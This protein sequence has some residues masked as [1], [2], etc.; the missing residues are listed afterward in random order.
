MDISSLALQIP[1]KVLV[2]KIDESHSI[3][4]LR[5][6]EKGYGVTLGNT[7]RRVL[8]SS[9]EGYAITAIKVGGVQHEFSTIQGVREDL[10]EIIL[11]LKQVRLKNLGDDADFGNKI[12]LR[13]NKP[14]FRAGDIDKVPSNF[15]VLN[16]D[17]LICNLEDSA[18]LDI[19]LYIEKG[20]GYHFADDN[21]SVDYAVGVIPIDSV[22]SPIV[23]V[24]YRVENV[25]VAQR[26][27]YEELILEVQTDGSLSPEEGLKQASQLVV[28]YLNLLFLKEF[29]LRSNEDEGVH[30][31]NEEKLIVQKNLSIRISDL[32]CSVRVMNCLRSA[33]V[34][35]LADLVAMTDFDMMKFRNFGKKSRDE[36]EQILASKNLRMGMDLSKYS[37]DKS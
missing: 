18:S 4:S 9:L 3:F 32:N 17:L 35:T 34:E 24:S 33:G 27:D 5:P 29:E 28:Q 37:L 11:N 6:L 19:E 25:R 20:R 8:L 7:L 30:V 13:I 16:P 22:F 31:L 15:K 23:R 12:A 14:E 1:E 2:E 36:I 10:V 21:K 26:T